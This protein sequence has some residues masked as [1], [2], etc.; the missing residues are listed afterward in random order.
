MRVQQCTRTFIDHLHPAQAF[1][2]D[3]QVCRYS[4]QKDPCLSFSYPSFCHLQG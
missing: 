1:H 3:H 2:W 4:C